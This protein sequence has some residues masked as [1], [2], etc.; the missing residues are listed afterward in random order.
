MASGMI[1]FE[2]FGVKETERMFDLL[3]DRMDEK[4][5][6]NAVR[7]SA[8][9]MR[10]PVARATPRKTGRLRTLIANAK[11]RSAG[12][13]RGFVRVGWL[14]PTR[15]E[16]GIPAEAK[17]YYPTA[18]EYGWRGKVPIP[19]GGS[20]SIGFQLPRPYIRRTTDQYTRQEWQ[21]ISRDIRAIEAEA[22]KLGRM[23]RFS[24]KAA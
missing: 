5:A 6:S 9:R 18:L 15:E 1:R 7:R 16:L 22:R 14:M 19:G 8:Y 4:V 17:G 11:V 24:R 3:P 21:Q 12:K 10:T 13:R 20:R 2:V 23:P